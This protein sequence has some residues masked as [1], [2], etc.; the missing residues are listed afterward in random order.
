MHTGIK[1]IAIAAGAIV[2]L[3]TGASVV[4]TGTASSA[5]PCGLSGHYGSNSQNTYYDYTIRNC[6]GYAVKRKVNVNNY[7]DGKC[8]T[9]RAHTQIRGRALVPHANRGIRGIKPC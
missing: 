6:H 9:I 1:R 5:A 3:T 8:H 2:A 4:A 7:P